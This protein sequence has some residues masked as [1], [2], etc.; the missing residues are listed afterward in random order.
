MEKP[1]KSP[2]KSHEDI[3]S[4]SSESPEKSYEGISSENSETESETE[5]EMIRKDVDAEQGV[6][7]IEESEHVVETTNEI[8]DMISAAEDSI[9][10]EM[11]I[12]SEGVPRFPQTL[13]DESS[14]VHVT[15]MD[16]TKYI[17]ALTEKVQYFSINVPVRM[18]GMIKDVL[19]VVSSITLSSVKIAINNRRYP[20]MDYPGTSKDN[21]FELHEI[22]HIVEF[23]IEF[24]KEL[25]FSKRDAILENLFGLIRSAE[26][27]VLQYFMGVKLTMVNTLEEMKNKA[28]VALGEIEAVT[29]KSSRKDTLENVDFRESRK[30]SSENGDFGVSATESSE[31][32]DF[33]GSATESSEN[34]DFR[35]SIR[36]SSG[37]GNFENST[38]EGSETGNFS[39]SST[40]SSESRDFRGPDETE[41]SIRVESLFKLISDN[42]NDVV[43][44][45]KTQLHSSQ[46]MSGSILERRTQQAYAA[47]KFIIG[48]YFRNTDEF[49]QNILDSFLVV[50]SEV[51]MWLQ[52][53]P[54]IPPKTLEIMMTDSVK[55]VIHTPEK[56]LDSLT[57]I[58]NELWNEIGGVL[59]GFVEY[60]DYASKGNLERTEIII[61]TTE[62]KIEDIL[63]QCFSF[64]DYTTEEIEAA[65]RSA[66]QEKV[67]PSEQP[68]CPSPEL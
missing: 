53:L 1:S 21:Y 38:K 60:V 44:D 8:M 50:Y 59:R 18:C 47:L 37:N 23:S 40:E 39:G 16:V 24:S 32:K 27:C 2:E 4:D 9:I 30:E 22:K 46:E 54:E 5:T 15:F 7:E 12:L 17:M 28:D 56:G 58:S 26:C 52:V 13:S 61:K 19:Q 48:N 31:N 45:A 66:I 29:K 49:L 51:N 55:R 34:G 65:L 14:I 42:V 33:G 41:E 11:K 62:K 43:R 67:T 64:T 35:G 36:G 63:Q 10:I 25:V 20:R 68:K 6:S 57:L 3:S